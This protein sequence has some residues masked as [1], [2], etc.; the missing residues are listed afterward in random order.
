MATG[1][2]YRLALFT[3]SCW[4]VAALGAVAGTALDV[5]GAAAEV[6][7]APAAGTNDLSELKKKYRR[8]DAIPFPKTNPFDAAKAELGRH[9]FFDPRLSRSGSVSCGSCHNPAFDWGDGLARGVGVTGVPLPRRT[10]SIANAAWLAT[11]MW[12]GRAATLEQQAALPITAE[13]EMGM[14]LE[15]VVARLKT[16][17]GYA[18]LFAAAFPNGEIGAENVLAALATYE[19]TI[20]S[21]TSSFDR[22]IEGDETAISEAAKRG[23]VLFNGAARCAKCHASWRLTDDSF[24]DIGLDSNDV[25][26]GQFVPPS[27]TIMQH[28]FKT[29]SLRDVRVT[30]PYMH[31]GSMTSLDEVID[32][33][34]KGGKARA[35]LSPEMKPVKLT[36]QE[37]DDLVAYLRT[38]QGPPIPIE[39]PRLP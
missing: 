35:S 5:G 18:P 10:P 2:S 28:A 33:Y 32:H 27:V 29:P 39:I 13:H 7:P 26:R 23:F 17:A 31:D 21:G 16:I 30:G 14:A 9:L 19:R 25:G 15:D 12:D 20:V 38:L 1:K 36:R 6:T 24:H 3:A 22:W 8:P 34:E 37:K 11:L 4:L